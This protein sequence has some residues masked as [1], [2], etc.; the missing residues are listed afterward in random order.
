MPAPLPDGYSLREAAQD[1]ADGILAVGIARDIAD[2]GAPDWSLEDVREEMGEAGPGGAVVVENADGRIVAFAMISGEDGRANVHPDATGRG[3][4]AHLRDWLVAHAREAGRSELRH[5][6]FGSDDAAREL[7]SAGGFEV[8]QRYWR[9]ARDL[10]G[11]EP[12]PVWPEGITP[13]AFEAATDERPA[14]ELVE[15]AFTDI[16]GNVSRPFDEWRPRAFGEQF[17]PELAT[18][19]GDMAGVALAERW[20]DDTGYLSYLAVARD[21]RGRGLGRALLQATLRNFADAG[22]KRGVLSVNGRNESATE[23]YRS[24]GMHVESR[25]DRFVKRLSS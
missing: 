16:S 14:H 21:W 19:A 22:L 17:A 8:D 11:A 2:V 13:R 4:G 3:I 7:L 20:E 24:A 1:D 25:A 15:E 18:V 6:V 23:L 10:D 5:P 12:A 9:M